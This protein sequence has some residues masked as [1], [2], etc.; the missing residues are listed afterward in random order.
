M[1]FTH[2]SAK[3]LHD[4][5]KAAAALCPSKPH[6]PVLGAVRL[7]AGK[8]VRVQATDLDNSCELLL[9]DATTSSPGEVV[10]ASKALL[11]ALKAA[12]RGAV[13]VFTTDGGGLVVRSEALGESWSPTIDPAEYP[14]IG[15]EDSNDEFEVVD[16]VEL[17]EML[18]G[19]V[20][21]AYRQPDRPNLT[22]VYF[23]EHGAVGCDEHRLGMNGW[24][25]DPFKTLLDT[26]IN[27]NGCALL[28]KTLV[29]ARQAMIRVEGSAVCVWTSAGK[30]W[31]RKVDAEYPEYQ[32]VLQRDAPPHLR[33]NAAALRQALDGALPSQLVRVLRRDR[34]RADRPARRAHR[35][36]GVR[37]QPS[38]RRAAR[39]AWVVL[40]RRP[41]RVRGP[42]VV[43]RSRRRR[44]VAPRAQPA[45]D[46]VRRPAAR[47]PRDL[48]C[49]LQEGR[50]E[51][52]DGRG[53]GPAAP[54]GRSPVGARRRC[55]GVTLGRRARRATSSPACSR[56]AP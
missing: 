15:A 5:V 33:V 1:K 38:P 49:E 43:R 14:L 2:P 23:D 40:A 56:T 55:G 12:G 32:K 54:T 21:F 52:V 48:P 34:E 3:A 50:H 30:V 11:A 44:E 25:G 39:R 17:R 8:R 26:T 19:T 13:T 36:A 27:G 46:G 28:A 31:T 22:G 7:I 16:A 42:D 20:P 10:V 35:Q 45:R 6:L 37:D 41:V 51:S 18:A 4:R 9:P 24:K 29:G 53:S 47:V